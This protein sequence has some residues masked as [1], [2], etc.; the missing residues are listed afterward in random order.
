MK[1]FGLRL[2]AKKSVLPPGQRTTYLGVVWDSTTMQA[3][4]SPARIES[5]LATVKRVREG[6]S[7]T[8]NQFQKLLDWMAAAS[9]V[10]TFGLLYMRPLQWCLR[11]RGFSPEGQP[12]LHY[13][14]HTAKLTCLRHVE[15]T[16]VPVTRPRVG[17]SVSSRNANDGCLPHG[18]GSGHEWPVQSSLYKKIVHCLMPTVHVL[19]SQPSAG[20]SSLP[21]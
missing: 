9:N 19:V 7:L 4:L 3:H 6:Q 1:D 10:I 21:Y 15:E 14:G 8:V 13:Q 17:D 18:L 16:V 20:P 2:N 11:T 5:I 12:I